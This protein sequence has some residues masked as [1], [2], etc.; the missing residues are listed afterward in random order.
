MPSTILITGGAGLVG[1]AL[2]ERALAS[3]ARVLVLD[4]LSTGRRENLPPSERIE[5]V[6]GD[7]CD[8]ELVGS[9]I[10]RVD[11]V[12]HLAAA[13]GV[14]LIL[15]RPTGTLRQSL[16]GTEIVMSSSWYPSASCA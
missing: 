8:D 1:S 16:L 12:F 9:L 13:V 10:R 6:H 15:E 7:V 3:G 11:R 4:N 5:L 2:C 14:R